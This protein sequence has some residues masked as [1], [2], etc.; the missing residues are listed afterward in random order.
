MTLEEIT[1]LVMDF[2]D[3]LIELYKESLN[4]IDDPHVQE[5]LQNLVALED[6]EK[7]RFAMNVARLQGI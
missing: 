7:R 2:E 1:R 3:A 4:E 6:T 5:V